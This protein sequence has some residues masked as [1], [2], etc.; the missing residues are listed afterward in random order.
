MKNSNY[1]E[2]IRPPIDKYKTLQFGSFDEIREV[3]YM[4]GKTYFEGKLNAGS[5]PLYKRTTN[6][7]KSALAPTGYT[8]TD[9]AQMVCK[10]SK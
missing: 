2:Y 3:G 8:F 9:L 1:C 10:V 4:H 7:A 5:L 6:K